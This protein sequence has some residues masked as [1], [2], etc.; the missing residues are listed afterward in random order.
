MYTGESKICEKVI[1]CIIKPKEFY[2]LSINK[3]KNNKK[4]Y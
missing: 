1:S 4:L 2:F 3:Y